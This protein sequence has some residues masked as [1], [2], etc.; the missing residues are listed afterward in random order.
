MSSSGDTHWKM[1]YLL[2]GHLCA[3]LCLVAQSCPTL[4]DPKD[5][6]PP[7]SSVHGI[8][9]ARIPEWVAM[10][11][12]R[13][14]SQPRDQT[15]VSCIVGGFFISWATMEAQGQLYFNIK[16]YHNST[17]KRI[18]KRIKQTYFSSIGDKRRD[19]TLDWHIIG[20]LQA[21]KKNQ[22]WRLCFQCC[23]PE[24]KYRL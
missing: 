16:Q 2:Q 3:V 21:K 1:L 8:L 7:G 20:I 17:F 22:T 5:C 12:S 10:P 6:S 18:G 9:H 24:W 11:S 15:Q 19:F 23:L 4:W 14:S 13:G